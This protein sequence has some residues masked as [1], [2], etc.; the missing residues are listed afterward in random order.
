MR[1]VLNVVVWE[2]I[3]SVVLL[4]IKPPFVAV[5]FTAVNVEDSDVIQKLGGYWSKF[6]T[7]ML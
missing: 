3:S 6:F 4:I 5:I 2:S 1:A 7:D